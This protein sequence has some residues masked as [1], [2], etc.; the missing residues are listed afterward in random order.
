MRRRRN[1]L[2]Y[3][4]NPEHQRHPRRRHRSRPYPHPLRLPF[5][6]PCRT[7]NRDRSLYHRLRNQACHP[8]RCHPHCPPRRD[9]LSRLSRHRPQ[10]PAQ[11]ASSSPP[12]L[13]LGH[14]RRPLPSTPDQ[15]R[16]P[17]KPAG[18]WT[19]YTRCINRHR[20]RSAS[21][22]RRRS[23]Q[24]TRPA[25]PGL[26]RPPGW[27][28]NRFNL[29]PGRPPRRWLNRFNPHPSLRRPV[30]PCPVR[31][32]RKHPSPRVSHGSITGWPRTSLPRCG[33]GDTVAHVTATTRSSGSGGPTASDA[34][35]RTLDRLRPPPRPRLAR[36]LLLCSPRASLDS[37]HGVPYRAISRRG[38]RSSSVSRPM[39][40]TKRLN[41]SSS[42]SATSGC[43]ST[44]LFCSQRSSG[45][46]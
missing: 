44:T 14:R 42:W 20:R 26:G 37:A 2:R 38:A 10:L 27:W 5:P 34:Q 41:A 9:K 12:R 15:R 23:R 18:C 21:S 4:Q 35:A 32:R 39:A 16:N 6:N 22:L 24:P 1:Q 7:R 25:C 43:C 40:S 11:A 8:R 17:T 19:G 30:L 36:P 29:H 31:V 3:P 33:A 45:L 46:R 28:L 13:R